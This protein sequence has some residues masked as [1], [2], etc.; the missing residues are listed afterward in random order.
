MLVE[1]PIW[2]IKHEK[3]LF[4]C[5][6]EP[7]AFY[8]HFVRP[9]PVYRNNQLPSVCLMGQHTCDNGHCIG[10]HELCDGFDDCKDASDEINCCKCA[11]WR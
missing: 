10:Q 3:H 11:H 6:L 2:I 9:I 5:I 8:C 1:L 7:S 4:L